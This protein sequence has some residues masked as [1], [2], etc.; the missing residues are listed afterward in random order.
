MIRE[1]GVGVEVELSAEVIEQISRI[2]ADAAVRAVKSEED[3][4]YKRRRKEIHH[5]TYQALSAYRKMKK[6]VA[7]KKY[8]DDEERE[9]RWR[10]MQDLMGDSVHGRVPDRIIQ[11]EDKRI[12]ENLYAIYRIETALKLYEEEVISH[13]NLEQG[14]RFSVLKMK[15]IDEDEKSITEIAETA[16]ISEKSAYRDI[17]KAV[18]EISI[19]IYGTP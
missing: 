6:V 2:A 11:D 9:I 5:K 15:F 14:R 1:D 3:Q 7:Q 4:A 8:S 12:Q 17:N 18:D 10:F 13:E 19:Y 16:G